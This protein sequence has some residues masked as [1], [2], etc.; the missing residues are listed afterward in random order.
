MYMAN[1]SHSVHPHTE[2][3]GFKKDSNVGRVK[4]L[5]A[6]KSTRYK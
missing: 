1:G 3:L 2:V 5:K 4:D 6:R